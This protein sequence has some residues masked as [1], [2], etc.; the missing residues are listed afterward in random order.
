ML[1]FVQ[2]IID[3]NL[4]MA[5]TMTLAFFPVP[6]LLKGTHVKE[7]SDI[8]ETRNIP[9][10]LVLMRRPLKYKR[11]STSGL[12]SVWQIKLRRLL[13]STV[14]L[15]GTEISFVPAGASKK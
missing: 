11:N 3:V 15:L 9:E 6:T 5:V 4:P 10:P 12:P 2:R 7:P 14:V 1:F 8:T 13:R